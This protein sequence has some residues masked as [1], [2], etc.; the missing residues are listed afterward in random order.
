M[1]YICCVKFEFHYFTCKN[2]LKFQG[3]SKIFKVKVFPD[4]LGL[5]YQIL[6]FSEIQVFLTA[7]IVGTYI[8]TNNINNISIYNSCKN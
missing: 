2:Y 3:F 5:K 6:N 8:Y 1:W 7:L 4:F